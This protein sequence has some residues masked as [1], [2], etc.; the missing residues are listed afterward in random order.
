MMQN[1]LIRIEQ[2][3]ANSHTDDQRYCCNEAS[4]EESESDEPL[5]LRSDLASPRFA[6]DSPRK[7]GDRVREKHEGTAPGDTDH[8]SDRKEEDTHVPDGTG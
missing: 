1:S 2:H 4:E 3:S 6:F 7:A 5:Q 8:R